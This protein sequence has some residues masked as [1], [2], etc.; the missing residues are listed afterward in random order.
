MIDYF[1]QDNGLKHVW[2]R[3]IIQSYSRVSG[4][5]DYS[6]LEAVHFG[7]RLPATISS[8]GE[9]RFISI[10]AWSVVK[11]AHML[12]Y[13]E[14]QNRATFRNKRDMFDRR[15]YLIRPNTVSEDDF[16]TCPCAPFGAC[17]TS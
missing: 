12:K 4:G 17:F 15:F 8:F 10:S 1:E 2:R 11:P 14:R 7:L 9:V 5:R 13:T 16:Q 3:V 6:L